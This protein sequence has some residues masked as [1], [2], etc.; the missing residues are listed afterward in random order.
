MRALIS[1]LAALFVI[2][3]PATSRGWGMDVH[4]YLTGPALDGLPADL[5]P[6]FAE[7]RAF[8]VEHAAD[9]DLWRVVGLKGDLGDE[10]PNHQLDID[11]LDEPAPFTNVPRDLTAFIARYGA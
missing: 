7:R 11:A 9:P 10:S 1:V 5:K 4:R 2:A 6:F 3:L 8:I